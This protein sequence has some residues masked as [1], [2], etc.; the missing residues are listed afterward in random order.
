MKKQFKQLDSI[1]A[2]KQNYWRFSPYHESSLD[3][4]LRWQHINP[5]LNSWLTQLTANEV[6]GLRQS[7]G[8]LLE[9]AKPFIAE[10]S[11]IEYLTALP[12][13]VGQDIDLP[14]GFDNGIPGRKLEQ[15]VSMSRSALNESQGGEW[16]EWC[17]G[18]GYLGRILSHCSS[19]AVTSF[20]Y[21]SCLCESGQKDADKLGLPMTFVQGDAFA[22][23]A[24]QVFTSAQHAVALHACGDLHVR[25]MHLA[26]K[27]RLPAISIAPCCYHL[28]NA[29]YYIPLSSI[30]KAS[31]LHFSKHEL[32]IPLQELVT[33]GKRVQHQRLQ[34]MTYRLGLDSM[35]RNT[36]QLETNITIPS[37]KKSLLSNGFEWFCRW[38]ANK[39]QFNLPNQDFERFEQVGKRRFEQMEKLS[40]VQD[41]F[42]R[43]LEMWLIYDKSL[44]LEEQGYSVKLS[45]FCDRSI[46]PRNILIQA[47]NDE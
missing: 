21:Q 20:E 41:L 44:Y 22:K 27:K 15:I 2:A 4:P 29:D 7:P 34:E 13:S 10:L 12:L 5:N 47:F 38:A 25:L 18:K 30:G 42:K 35:L 6:E 23:E 17:A 8:L 19:Q 40:L 46:S 14:K 11:E 31:S 24:E 37:I 43:A 32:R 45:T 9:T 3:C 16:L 1:L 33:G 26:T 39:K 36:A 28:I